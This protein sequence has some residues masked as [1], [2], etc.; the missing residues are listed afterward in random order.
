MSQENKYSGVYRWMKSTWHAC[1]LCPGWTGS[2]L[3][4]GLFLTN[5]FFL[6]LYKPLMKHYLSHLSSQMKALVCCNWAQLFEIKLR[7]LNGNKFFLLILYCQWHRFILFTTVWKSVFVAVLFSC[8]F[9]NTEARSQLQ[10]NER[11]VF[12]YNMKK[13]CP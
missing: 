2:G 3:F 1:E 8:W 6:I 4:R 12:V 11:T 5:H 10:G 7:L 9:S 13:L